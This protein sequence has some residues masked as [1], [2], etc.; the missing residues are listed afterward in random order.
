MAA[1]VPAVTP[2]RGIIRLEQDGRRRLG[3]VPVLSE[4]MAGHVDRP[5]DWPRRAGGVGIGLRQF[6]SDLEAGPAIIA[7]IERKHFC[8]RVLSLLIDS[9][10]AISDSEPSS[11]IL[12]RLRA[13]LVESYRFKRPGC[14]STGSIYMPSLNRSRRASPRARDRSLEHARQP[15]KGSIVSRVTRSEPMYSCSISRIPQRKI[16]KNDTVH[17]HSL[18]FNG[19][20]A[21][22]IKIISRQAERRLRRAA[23]RRSD[24][25]TTTSYGHAHLNSW[26]GRRRGGRY[27]YRHEPT[28]VRPRPRTRGRFH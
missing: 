10:F 3:A 14:I 5:H 1:T 17:L 4:P 19:H 2:S 13:L 24:P 6:L 18:F 25:P 26:R 9:K 28:G 7:A 16:F 20:L 21:F 23:V 15:G 22:E 11:K 8:Y 27:R 12:G